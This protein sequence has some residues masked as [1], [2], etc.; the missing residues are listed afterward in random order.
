MVNVQ[1]VESFATADAGYQ[2][3]QIV[4]IPRW[5]AAEL[6]MRGLAN[7]TDQPTDEQS[8]FNERFRFGSGQPCLFL[9]FVGEFGHAIMHHVRFIHFHE[10]SRKVVCCR[11]GDEVLFPIADEFVT[12]WTDPTPDETRAGSGRETLTWPQIVATF[13]DHTPV[14]TGNIT[15]YQEYHCPIRLDEKIDLKPKRRGLH[16]DV[17]LGIRERK[18]CAEKNWTHW[19]AVADR[20]TA[21]GFTVA[22]AGKRPHTQDVAGQLH[23]SS[24][25]PDTDAA[26]ELIQNARLYIGTDTGVSHLAS[27]IGDCPMIVFREEDHYYRTY[28]PR[29]QETCGK[30]IELDGVWNDPQAV[31]TAAM[32]QLQRH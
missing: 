15:Y 9:P 23:H 28:I 11:K 3:G 13:P 19:Q 7:E 2:A 20:I 31:A 25:Y 21:A 30:V 8:Q 29:M 6:L 4:T 16:A 12:N 17:V 5:F 1:I 27:L 14:E 24:D 22:V 18:F 10:A 26:V 32:N